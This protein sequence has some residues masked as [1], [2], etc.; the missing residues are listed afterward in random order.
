MSQLQAAYTHESV[1]Q[2]LDHLDQSN[3]PGRHAD[4]RTLLVL[5][6]RQP[7]NLEGLRTDLLTPAKVERDESG[8][9]SH[10]LLPVTDEYVDYE[11]LL[12]A[13]GLDVAV[14]WAED[15]LD[16][17]A[18]EA[19]SDAGSIAAWEPRP[20]EGDGW[21]VISIHDTEDG[22]IALYVRTATR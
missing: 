5:A 17:A 21:V 11:K 4:A 20:P 14:V 16:E 2:A 3:A 18:T 15:Q 9:W 13:F 10:D 8:Y 19:M 6:P 7:A 12:G 1:I 22:A